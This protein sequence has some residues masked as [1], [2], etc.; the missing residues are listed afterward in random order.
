MGIL[1]KIKNYF[2]KKGES[3]KIYVK[4]FLD[5]SNLGNYFIDYMGAASYGITKGEAIKRMVNKYNE[6]IKLDI[7]N[8]HLIKI[9]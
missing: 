2:I 9:L 1:D 7:I 8:S 5:K 4:V 6:Y 3:Y